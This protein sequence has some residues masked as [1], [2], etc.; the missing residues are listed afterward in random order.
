M[1]NILKVSNEKT[2]KFGVAL[3]RQRQKLNIS[4]REI[5]HRLNVS[6]N[7]IRRWEQN[8]SKPQLHLRIKLV[9]FFGENNEV[10]D[11]VDELGMTLKRQLEKISPE[12][13]I[14]FLKY[15]AQGSINERK[16]MINLFDQIV[17]WNF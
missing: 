15:M 2:Y 3:K 10:T 1:K 4:Q 14:K 17:K 16:K 6:V 5:A 12:E 7:T 11:A 8:K 9:K 13:W